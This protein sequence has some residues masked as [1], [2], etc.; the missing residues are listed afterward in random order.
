MAERSY[1]SV[2]SLPLHEV[3][4]DIVDLQLDKSGISMFEIAH[5]HVF[6]ER[7]SPGDIMFSRKR[8]HW[9]WQLSMMKSR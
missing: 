2:R 9:L 4:G 3:I 7:V 8:I 5:E 1:D 6:L